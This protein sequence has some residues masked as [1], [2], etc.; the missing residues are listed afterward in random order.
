MS[1]LQRVGREITAEA[2]WADRGES[3]A[4]GMNHPYHGHRLAM[5]HTLLESLPLRGQRVVDLGCGEGVLLERVARAGASVVG[6]DVDGDMVRRT[7][8][9]L[10][11]TSDNVELRQG[12]PEALS[13]MSDASVDL[14]LAVNVLAYFTDAQEAR[15]YQDLA[16]IVRSGGA[17]LVTHSNELF[18]LF[19]LNSYTVEFF[20]RHLVDAGRREDIVSLLSRADEPRRIVHNIRENPLN[21][22][23]KLAAAGF[24]EMRQEFANFHDVP[25]LLMAPDVGVNLSSKDY[26]DTLH[27]PPE[28][29]WKLMLQCS[30]F[31]SLSRRVDS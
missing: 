23:H 22:R 3:Y 27:W 7:E 16:R 31:G 17:F 5:V 21:Y 20:A 29:R 24:E 14:V 19:T 28:H 18:D 30:M 15:F 26:P 8:A 10:A 12:G 1:T 11:R 9:R 4:A 13:S 25:P 6:I 2:Y